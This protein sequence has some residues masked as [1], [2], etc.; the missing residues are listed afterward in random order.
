MTSTDTEMRWQQEGYAPW[1]NASPF[2]SSF[3]HMFFKAQD[4]RLIFRVEVVPTH[5]NGFQVAHGGFLATLADIWLACNVGHALPQTRFVTASLNVDY[6]RPVT[7]GARLESQ[8]DR[9][10]LGSRLCHA[11][12]AIL[13]D[14]RPAVAMRGMFA[15][16][17]RP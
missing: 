9:L 16:L 8:I 7:I 4:D 10:K 6:L 12:G 2:L 3:A 13:A 5:C 11:S 15:I 1:P 17:D 14:D